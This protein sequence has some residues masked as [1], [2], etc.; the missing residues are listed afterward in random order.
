MDT[1]VNTA[2][3][4]T[5]GEEEAVLIW[6]RDGVSVVEHGMGRWGEL[7]EGKEGLDVVRFENAKGGVLLELNEGLD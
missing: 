6:S 3:R 7:G 1:H 4:K 5:I 2:F